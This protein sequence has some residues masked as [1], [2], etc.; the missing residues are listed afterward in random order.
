MEMLSIRLGSGVG[1]QPMASLRSVRQRRRILFESVPAAPWMTQRLWRS[2]SGA[3]ITALM[4][5]CVPDSRAEPKPGTQDAPAVATF[6][7]SGAVTD[8]ADRPLADVSLALYRVNRGTGDDKLKETRT[9]AEGR[10]Q[11]SNLGPLAGGP[12][13]Y[14]SYYAIVATARGRASRIEQINTPGQ[15]KIP[16][17]SM[18]PAETLRGQ[19][20]DAEGKP[21]SGA[22]VWEGGFWGRPLEGAMNATTDLDGKFAITDLATRGSPSVGNVAGD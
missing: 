16:P 11:F 6:V 5:F 10:Y 13:D 18:P 17:F 19:V 22:L 8:E 4:L 15:S 21:V 2:R 12:G 1:V 3:L 20:V 14:R 7:I 9:D